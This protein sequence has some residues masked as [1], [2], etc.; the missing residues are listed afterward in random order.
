MDNHFLP[1]FVAFDAGGGFR[2]RLFF[3]DL[4]YFEQ[5]CKKRIVSIS[6]WIGQFR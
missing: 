1:E 6:L 3:C 2:H 5:K 4:T